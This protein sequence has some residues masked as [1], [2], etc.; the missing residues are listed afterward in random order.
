[1]RALFA[2][3][4]P[5]FAITFQSVPAGSKRVGAFSLLSLGA[6]RVPKIVGTDAAPMQ[7]AF[8]PAGTSAL[9]TVSSPSLS[10][11]GAYLV[12]LE[13]QQVDFVALQSPPL[14]AGVVP[15]AGRAYIAQAHPEG[16]ITFVSL[17]DG[18]LQTL[19]GFELAAR[20]IQ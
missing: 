15:A 12:E 13:N 17:A 6:Q 18:Q 5:R 3:P 19:T 11:F 9:I 4:N 8:S 7:V 20:I 1:M 10:A 2:A 16:R 14:A